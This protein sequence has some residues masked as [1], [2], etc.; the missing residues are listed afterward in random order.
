MKAPLFALGALLCGIAAPAHAQDPERRFH[1]G[2]DAGLGR[3]NR[4]FS[5]YAG[6]GSESQATAWKLRFGWRATPTWSVEA[7]YTD[8][9]E[10]DTTLPVVLLPSPVP[11][12]AVSLA[13][14]P[15]TS[16]K[17]FDISVVGTWPLGESFYLDA[18]AG[19]ARRE[20]KTTTTPFLPPSP[21]YRAKDG[22]LALQYGIGFGFRLTEAWDLGVTWT[23]TSN[24]EGDFEFASNQSD[25]SMLSLGVRFHL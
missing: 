21:T 4:S 18:S 24:L 1:V 12:A 15:A 10:Y 16:A 6:Q 5:E 13:R 8:F 9:G 22:D 19:L 17:A 3:I 11:G 2:L 14:E 23:N 7:G 25:P 20:F